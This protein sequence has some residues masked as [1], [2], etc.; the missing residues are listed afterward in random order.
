[1]MTHYRILRDAV[2]TAANL[3]TVLLCELSSHWALQPDKHEVHMAFPD[4]NVIST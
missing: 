1:M 2:I 4:I 3:I